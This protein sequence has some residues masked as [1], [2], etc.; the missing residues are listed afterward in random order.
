MRGLDVVRVLLLFSFPFKGITYPCAFVRWFSIINEECDEDTGM[1]M[2]Q[3]AV[4]EDGLPDVS[5]IHLD[6][7]FRAVHL[8]P[9]YGE[10]Q[11]PD[12]V[13]HHN[14]LDAF[15]GFYINKYADHHA[16]EIAY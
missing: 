8:L 15:A 16:F 2:V 11:V 13:S 5:V 3:P 1:W 4:T 9:I 14:S 6:C 12:N 10:T 7:V